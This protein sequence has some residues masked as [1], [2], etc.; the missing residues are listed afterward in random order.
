MTIDAAFKMNYF[1]ENKYDSLIIRV[2]NN[3]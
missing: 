2:E 1:R 3:V